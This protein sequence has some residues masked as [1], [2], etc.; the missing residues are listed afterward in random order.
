MNCAIS[1]EIQN[2][3]SLVMTNEILYTEQNMA[4]QPKSFTPYNW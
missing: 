3:Q 4:N 2:F 1:K